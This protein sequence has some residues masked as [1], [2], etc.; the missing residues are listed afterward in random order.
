M[1][2]MGV[3]GTEDCLSGVPTWAVGPFSAR[4]Q[5]KGWS[6]SVYWNKRVQSVTG[7]GTAQVTRGPKT[8]EN[9]NLKADK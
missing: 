8:K 2:S 1:G 9:L 4:L 5:G 7:K 6:R 3:V